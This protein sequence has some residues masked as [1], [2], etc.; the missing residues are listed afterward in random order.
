MTHVGHDGGGMDARYISSCVKRRI[1]LS[2]GIVTLG[3][4][5]SP[6]AQDDRLNHTGFVQGLNG[7]IAVYASQQTHSWPQTIENSFSTPRYL[8]RLTHPGHPPRVA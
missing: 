7:E 1:R 5:P 3:T 4:D 2:R 6:P 8:V